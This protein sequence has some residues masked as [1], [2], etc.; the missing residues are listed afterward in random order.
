MKCTGNVGF[1]AVNSRQSD[2]AA[3]SQRVRG[4][5]GQSE[6]IVASAGSKIDSRSSVLARLV[7]RTLGELN[8]DN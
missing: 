2:A 8:A 7:G 3:V 6:W 4:E 1:E 5:Q